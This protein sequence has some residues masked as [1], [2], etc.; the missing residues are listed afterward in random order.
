M[1]CGVPVL[2]TLVGIVL[3]LGLAVIGIDWNSEDIAKK[4]SYILNNET[5]YMRLKQAG[6][7]I[8]KQFEKKEAIK[9]YADKLKEVLTG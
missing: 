5:E 6:P 8:A 9:N 7:E 3:D 2:A 1:A 4:A